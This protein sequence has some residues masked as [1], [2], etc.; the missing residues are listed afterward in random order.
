MVNDDD[1]MTQKTNPHWWRK[2]RASEVRRQITDQELQRVLKLDHRIWDILTEARNQKFSPDY[3]R[4]E[5]YY[6]LK[7]RIQGIVGHLAGEEAR[8]RGLATSK[9]YD[10]VIVAVSSLLPPD[11][12]DLIGS[13]DLT[14]EEAEALRYPNGRNEDDDA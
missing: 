8:K 9:A 4:I 1:E 12:T 14:D 6:D 3:N 2:Q 7:H 13:G 5:T 11:I 10:A